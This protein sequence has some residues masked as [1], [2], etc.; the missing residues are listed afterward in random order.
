MISRY[1][2]PDMAGL[3]AEEHKLELWKKVEVLALEA[4]TGLG[5]VPAGAAQAL[6][7]VPTPTPGQVAER[8]E[9]T[10]HDLA[11]F[12]DLLSEAMPVGREWVHYGL[13]SSD[14]LD[15]AGGAV[16]A[17]AIDLLLER[18]SD[19]FEL[20]RTRAKEHRAT[21]MLG[22]THG[23]WAEPTTFGLKLAG[24]AFELARGHDRLREA[25]NA[26]AVGKVSGA[27]GTY[28]HVSPAVEEH[29]CTQMGLGIEPASTQVVA[30]DRHAQFL[31]T[32]ALI[33]ASLER[34]A[35]EVRHLQRSEVAEVREPFGAGQKGSSAMP[36]KRNPIISERITGMARLLRGYAQV[37]LENV[38][39]WHERD[40]S[41]SSAER[42]VLPDACLALHYMLVRMSHL[43]EGL[44]IDRD[45]M[46]A[47]LDST[48]GLIY[49]QGALLAM[50]EAGL[51]RDAAY[52][53]VQESALK[54][55]ET[56]DHLFDLLATDERVP[57]DPARLQACFD[58]GS[59][60]VH[61]AVIWD[62]LDRL[63][64]TPSRTPE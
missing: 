32:V 3:W 10:G 27:V 37:G 6:A 24:W 41:H 48:R 7:A 46:R 35:T 21:V 29:V 2:L 60:L 1:S 9:I 26:V 51:T 33:G 40:I 38:A 56:G 11:A 61:S 43:I 59:H 64:L 45:R 39:L 4:W 54:S 42:V 15:T 34:I 36:H 44:V 14:V 18:L 47:N 28:A 5:V 31:S 62:R 22:R 12:V 50:V 25:R 58:P 53:I 17:R 8:E 19:L 20:V 23:I 63:R 16:M 55:W 13:T 57:L 30:R 49:S 52:R